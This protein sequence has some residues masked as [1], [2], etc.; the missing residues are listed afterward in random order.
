MV[1]YTCPRCHHET[2]KKYNIKIHYTRKKSCQVLFE[3]VSLEDCLKQLDKPKPRNCKY[4]EKIFCRKSYLEKHYETCSV[5][6]KIL[7]HENQLK[8]RDKEIERLK[9]EYPQ[10]VQEEPKLEEDQFIYIIQTREFINSGESIYKLGKTRNPKTRLSSYPNG[11]RVY[12]LTKC[13]D[14]DK[15]EKDLLEKFRD[16]FV[17]KTDIGKEYFGGD[18]DCMIKEI[19]L[20]LF[21]MGSFV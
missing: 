16:K 10:E 8:E 14:C 17:H 12:L 2:D 7:E 1:K 15:T 6:K 4:C 3:D 20:N 9:N 5:K 21:I 11:S 19:F 18:V 13:V